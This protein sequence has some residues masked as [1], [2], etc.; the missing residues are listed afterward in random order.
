MVGM[1]RADATG[2]AGI[3][4]GAGV[5]VIS[6]AMPWTLSIAL[7]HWLF[8]AALFVTLSGCWWLLDIHLM[9]GRSRPARVSVCITPLL[10][11]LTVIIYVEIHSTN[12]NL[13][14]VSKPDSRAVASISAHTPP[15]LPEPSAPSVG[16]SLQTASSLTEPSSKPEAREYVS[17]DFSDLQKRIERLNGIQVIKVTDLYVGKWLK[18]RGRVGS[19]AVTPGRDILIIP[20]FSKA[21]RELQI[22]FS[23]NER[24]ES[25]ISALKSGDSFSA[26][27]EI[28]YIENHLVALRKCELT[29]D[30]T[31]ETSSAS[32]LPKRNRN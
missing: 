4:I 2:I 8:W 30:H 10:I 18:T 5:A 22:L 11:L 31:S 9:K 6:V 32:P 25:I 21:H 13:E 23:F 15:P 14:D 12:G 20:P 16:A 26:D 17:I 1:E 27:C 29:D 24:W 7:R 3:V 19:I 28:F